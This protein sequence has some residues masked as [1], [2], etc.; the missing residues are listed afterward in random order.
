MLKATEG[1]QVPVGAVPPVPLTETPVHETVMAETGTE[2]Q[3]VSVEAL[4]FI[5]MVHALFFA[6]L[7]TEIA[8]DAVADAVVSG[9]GEEKV[10]VLGVAMKELIEG[11]PR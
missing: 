7:L 11:G 4:E 10:I 9:S 2:P 5:V 3:L 6:E 1:S 8:T